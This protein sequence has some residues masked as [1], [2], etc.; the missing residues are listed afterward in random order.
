LTKQPEADDGNDVT[1]FHIRGANAMESNRAHGRKGGFVKR[2]RM[3]VRNPGDQQARHAGNLS[4]HCKTC[5]GTSYA[6]ADCNIGD[7]VADRDHRARA[8][9]TECR[10]LLQPATHCLQGGQKSVA[11][12]FA[13]NVADQIGPGLGFLQEV[14]TGELGRGSF[15]TCRHQR[16]RDSYQDAP[17]QQLRGGNVG[18][19]NL[20]GPGCWRTCFMRSPPAAP[21][22]R[23]WPIVKNRRR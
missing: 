7:T 23:R 21:Q 14:F 8:A 18:H 17:G 1:E 16:N 12:N 4:M 6:I 5:P 20:A 2:D 13:D 22:S 3:G 15:S 10:R 11:A 9:V 19:C